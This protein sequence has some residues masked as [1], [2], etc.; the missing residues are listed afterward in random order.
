MCEPE[1]F[2]TVVLLGATDQKHQLA[3][4]LDGVDAVVS[5]LHGAGIDAQHAIFDATARAGAMPF[6]R[7][8]YGSEHPWRKVGDDRTHFHP[9][10]DI[11]QRW[12][13][14]MLLHPVMVSHKMPFIV[15]SRR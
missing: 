15:S 10:L 11:Q 14:H 4:Q 8:D 2:Q 6:V 13:E 12:N 3:K 9:Y 7:S 5:A 1:A